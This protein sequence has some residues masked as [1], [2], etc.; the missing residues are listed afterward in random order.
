MSKEKIGRITSRGFEPCRKRKIWSGEQYINNDW[1]SI[2]L[3]KEIKDNTTIELF[4][5]DYSPDSGNITGLTRA[6][7]GI[8]KK[9]SNTQREEWY[10]SFGVVAGFYQHYDIGSEK[11]QIVGRIQKDTPTVLELK[12]TDYAIHPTTLKEIYEIIE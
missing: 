7:K 3:Q 8:L 2:Q 10:F 11:V 6:R 4:F 5:E 12:N 1:N 9:A